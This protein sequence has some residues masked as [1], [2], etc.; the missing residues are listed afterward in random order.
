MQLPYEEVGGTLSMKSVLKRRSVGFLTHFRA[1][2]RSSH[3]LLLRFGT[4]SIATDYLGNRGENCV[5]Q[6]KEIGQNGLGRM[7]TER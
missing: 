2:E 3:Q 5:R 6:M 7:P 4:D 1:I